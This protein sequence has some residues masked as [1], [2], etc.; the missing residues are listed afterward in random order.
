MLSDKAVEDIVPLFKSLKL[1]LYYANDQL[2]R[3]MQLDSVSHTTP[4]QS[5]F[6][7]CQLLVSCHKLTGMIPSCSYFPQSENWNVMPGPNPESDSGSEFEPELKSKLKLK[8]Q[9]KL[10]SKKMNPN[11]KPKSISGDTG[12]SIGTSFSRPPK[13]SIEFRREV[14]EPR[15][16]T[17]GKAVRDQHAYKRV[18]HILSD[19]RPRQLKSLPGCLYIEFNSCE[20][21]HETNCFPPHRSE[22]EWTASIYQRFFLKNNLP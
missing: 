19:N 10:N 8:R 5:P 21:A 6:D 22:A 12:T 7:R 4:A 20:L 15:G 16:I 2:Y 14:L 1:F 3:E 18:Q 13:K 11:L 9:W 17:A